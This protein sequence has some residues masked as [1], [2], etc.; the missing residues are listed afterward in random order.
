MFSDRLLLFR[1]KRNEEDFHSVVERISVSLRNGTMNF[2]REKIRNYYLKDTPVENLFLMEYMP[3]AKGTDVKVYLTALMYA[4]FEDLSNREIASYLNISEEEV[5]AAWNYWEKCGVIRKH[6]LAPD[7]R[8][9]YTVE[10]LSLREGLFDPKEEESTEDRDWPP[11]AAEHLS[12]ATVRSVFTQV[13]EITGRIPGSREMQEIVNW[14]YKDTLSPELICFAY[15]YCAERVR[16][17]KFS[18]IAAVM[19]NWR[20]SGIG[21]VEEA[22]KM[23]A[24]NDQKYHQYYRVM[25]ALGFSR[26]P[27][28]DE[29]EKMN[30]WFDEMGFSIETVLQACSRTSG[31]SNPNINY[32]NGILRNWSAGKTASSGSRVPAG[33]NAVSAVNR[34]YEEIR[35]SH[36]ETRD[37][38]RAEI[39][40]KIPHIRE[41]EDRIRKTNMA[42][43]RMALG[44][45]HRSASALEQEREE[46]VREKQLLLEQYG[47][48][49]DYME[50]HYDCSKC[51]D[52][53]IL[54]DGSRCN[55][56]AEKLRATVEAEA[57]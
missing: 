20:D 31:I 25:K 15:R 48:P 45:S 35:R 9:H 10:F 30:S 17:T 16:N 34:K 39:Y 33:K 55:C 51:K 12:D 32:V 36:A 41:L 56:F 37:T 3:Q 14:L 44:G 4:D 50:L 7:D 21:T 46:L 43:T 57:R 6:Y 54:D 49:A 29:K 47:Y 27:T 19:K 42:Y 38:H 11:E 22:E 2:R 8:F 1:K 26:N 28:E 53:G 23:L 5:L 24:E 52:T 13:Q 40:R 18:Y